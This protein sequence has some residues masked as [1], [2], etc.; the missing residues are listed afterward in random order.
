VGERDLKRAP[1]NKDTTESTLGKTNPHD[2]TEPR[3]EVK[4]SRR[5]SGL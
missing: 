2:P 3:K 1:R 5:V 4:E